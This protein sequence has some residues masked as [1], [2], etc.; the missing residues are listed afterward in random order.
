MDSE[1]IFVDSNALIYKTF[2][3]FDPLKH[4]QVF[5]EIS[6]IDI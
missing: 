5:D 4:Q 6:L 3:D 1:K 2:P